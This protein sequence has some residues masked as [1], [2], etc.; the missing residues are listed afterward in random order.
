MG[1]SRLLLLLTCLALVGSLSASQASAIPDR[2]SDFL[3]HKQCGSFR[4]PGL[5]TAVRIRVVR[6]PVGC[7]RAYRVVARF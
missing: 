1:M 4:V 6:G 7:E 3:S 5:L 2:Q